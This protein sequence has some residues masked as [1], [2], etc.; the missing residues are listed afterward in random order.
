MIYKMY[1]PDIQKHIQ[2]IKD[3]SLS[4]HGFLSLFKLLNI[5]LFKFYTL[6]WL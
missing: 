1:I 4:V 5:I 2:N 3:Y 6:F